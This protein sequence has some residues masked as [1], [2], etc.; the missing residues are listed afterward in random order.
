MNPFW[1]I[2][3]LGIAAVLV[4]DTVASIA[5]LTMGFP[6]GY[7]SIGSFLIYT[8]IGYFAFRRCGFVLSIGAAVVVE[9]VDATL[10][11]F[12]SWQIGP[13]ALPADQITTSILAMTLGFVL[14]LAVVC[15]SIGSAVA[16]VAHGPRQKNNA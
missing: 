7:A 16:R 13:G 14:V 2:V 9:L 12:I 4:F 3:G 15:S 8:M 1:K 10:G 11:W 6:Y 5:S